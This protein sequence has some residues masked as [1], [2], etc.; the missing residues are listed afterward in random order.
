MGLELETGILDPGYSDGSGIIP[1]GPNKTT[2]EKGEKSTR[3]YRLLDFNKPA[4][5]TGRYVAFR[6]EKDP[7]RVLITDEDGT[8]LKEVIY[9][10]A[11][12]VVDLQING[13]IIPKETWEVGVAERNI[14]DDTF[15]LRPPVQFIGGPELARPC[16][17]TVRF[18]PQDNSIDILI[19]T[20]PFNPT[21]K[22]LTYKAKP[23]EPT[24]AFYQNTVLKGE[25][26]IGRYDPQ[27]LPIGDR[28]YVVNAV[29]DVRKAKRN[30]I[31]IAELV[32]NNGY[33]LYNPLG[34]R[35]PQE[36]FP[37]EYQAQ[38]DDSDF[39]WGPEAPFLEEAILPNGTPGIRGHIVT[40]RGPIQ[41]LTEIQFS[42]TDFRNAETEANNAGRIA[43]LTGSEQQII[44]L[45]IQILGKLIDVPQIEAGHGSGKYIQARN[46]PGTVDEPSAMYPWQLAELI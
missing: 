24:Q 10:S 36:A 30:D 23:K 29:Y 18:S 42:L 27:F 46:L 9:F 38:S 2:R 44:P 5:I 7:E 43:R 13:N 6:D 14:G 26:F 19:H 37:R 40:H 1:T 20:D 34:I 17:P 35:I 41:Q 8:P 3:G 21:Q 11:G 28:I 15:I 22:W 33:L 32:T 45:P 31:E 12:T 25:P 16:A 4:D 39:W